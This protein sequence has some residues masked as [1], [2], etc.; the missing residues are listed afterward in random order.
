[1][2]NTQD[3]AGRRGLGLKLKCDHL[4]ALR[5]DSLRSVAGMATA[6]ER[7]DRGQ[8]GAGHRTPPSHVRRGSQRSPGAPAPA[9]LGVCA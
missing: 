1:M 8:E 2:N 6:P 5:F 3:Q 4:R 7:A 9:W